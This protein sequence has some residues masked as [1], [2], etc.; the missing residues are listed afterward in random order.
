MCIVSSSD[1]IL[2]TIEANMERVLLDLYK[3]RGYSGEYLHIDVENLRK[4]FFRVTNK[5]RNDIK[6][7]KRNEET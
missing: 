4:E 3:L 7:R 5:L 1:L 2:N 6:K